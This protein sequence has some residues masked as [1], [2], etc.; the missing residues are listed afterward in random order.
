MNTMKH[1]K[2]IGAILLVTGTT[3]G[4][5]ML[6]LPVSSGMSGFFPSLIIFVA[7][8]ALMLYTAFLMLEAT[9][10]MGKDKNLISMAQQT[11][12]L[13]GKILA[14]GAYLF[15]LYLLNIAY[16]SGGSKMLTD[17]IKIFSG[18][19]IPEWAGA[20]PFLLIF[21]SFVYAGTKAIDYLN[22]IFM[23]GLFFTYGL[24][25]LFVT[26]HIDKTMLYEHN[27]TS[28]PLAISVIVTA[29]GFHII[30]PTL[31]T[32]LDRD[33]KKIRT[34]IFIGSVMPLL[35]YIFWQFMMLGV[36]PIEGETGIIAAWKAGDSIIRPL[37]A[38]I[39]NPWVS[40][41][42]SFLAFFVIVTSFLGVAISLVDFLSDG[43]RVK[44]TPSGKIILLAAAFIPSLL[45][46]L[47]Y[48]RAFLS[49]LGYAG[50]FG[51]VILLCLLPAAMVWSGR[52]RMNLGAENR[53]P[54]GR[55]ALVIVIVIS[56][57]I[58]AFEIAQKAGWLTIL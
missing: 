57:A 38:I 2:L 56:F 17:A 3:V 18:I 24:I 48:P 20:L 29:F 30:I 19:S 33:V 43:L 11:L 31:V 16:I 32:Y 53:T 1:H 5:G 41:T 36:V 54:G 45:V 46:V 22:R 12:G 26:P 25:I 50:A 34:A 9:M 15:L 14:W 13:P 23:M 49:A 55:I 52:Y 7:I 37:Q 58:M 40:L 51:V 39:A 47:T 44:K 27:Y 4:A 8:W 10:W 6:A 35:A 28:L 42:S 21:G